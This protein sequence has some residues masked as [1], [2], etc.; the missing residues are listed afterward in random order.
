MQWMNVLLTGGL[1]EWRCL[2]SRRL[3]HFFCTI[4]WRAQVKCDGNEKTNKNN[5][6]IHLLQIQSQ[7]WEKNI[8]WRL[9]KKFIHHQIDKFSL[10]FF[11]IPQTFSAFLSCLPTPPGILHK[12]FFFSFYRESVRSRRFYVNYGKL[13]FFID[14]SFLYPSSERLPAKFERSE[15]HKSMRHLTVKKPTT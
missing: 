9:A 8:N 7:R 1:C 11:S 5:A 2:P 10:S 4:I 13:H 15:F 12:Q 14:W 3:L 6:T